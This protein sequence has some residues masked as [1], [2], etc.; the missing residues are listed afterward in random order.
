V[1]RRVTDADDRFE[2]PRC[3]LTHNAI[4]VSEFS[5]EVSGFSGAARALRDRVR[6]PASEPT[7]APTALNRE[8]A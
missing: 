2:I 6:K 8:T 4:T 7:A 1:K 3:T 5:A